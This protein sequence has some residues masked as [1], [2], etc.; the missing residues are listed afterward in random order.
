MLHFEVSHMGRECRLEQQH[1]NRSS[2]IHSFSLD[3]PLIFIFFCPAS[4]CNWRNNNIFFLSFFFFF[5]MLCCTKEG[6][7]GVFIVWEKGNYEQ[8]SLK[9]IW[10]EVRELKQNVQIEKDWSSGG[11][12][13]Q[14]QTSY[15]IYCSM[16]SVEKKNA[17]EHYMDR[18]AYSVCAY[19]CLYWCI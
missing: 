7:M 8:G 16:Y 10:C 17:N 3:F 11:G 1:W 9:N 6:W 5:T 14:D 2:Y 13:W 4:K 12:G 18:C 19:V 15:C